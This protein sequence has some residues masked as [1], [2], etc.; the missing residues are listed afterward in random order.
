MK[1]VI[2]ITGFL[3][4]GMSLSFAQ[5][6]NAL[7]F[8]GV[9][10]YVQTGYSGI[11]GNQAR[12][13][14][15]WIRTTAN[16][17][18]SA[19][20]SQQVIVDWGSAVTGGRCTFNILWGNSIRFE[21]QGN[22]IGGTTPVNDGIWHHLAMTY[23]PLAVNK[24]KLYI[25]GQL[26]TEGNLTVP[27]NT[28]AQTDLRIGMRVDGVKNFTG[29]IDEVRVW[30]IVRTQS[31]ISADMNKEYC[32]IPNG[33]EVYYKANEGI[34]NGVN[35]G[36][37]TLYNA[38]SNNHHGTLTNFAL[39]GGV[40]NWV[41]G[42]GISSGNTSFSFQDTACS[43]YMMP[44][45]TL[46]DSSGIYVDVIPNNAGCDSIITIDVTIEQLDW[47]V[48]VDAN[49]MFTATS[50]EPNATYQWIDCGTFTPIVGE[51]SN[52]F[53]PLVNGEYAL[54]I[55]AG[56]CRDTSE[57]VSIANIGLKETGLFSVE[58]FPNPA[59]DVVR[60]QA[61]NR[62]SLRVFNAQGLCVYESGRILENWEIDVS[63]W[64]AGFYWVSAVSQ[65]GN[66]ERVLVK[67]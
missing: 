57:C 52:T 65:K 37:Q 53:T 62:V 50:T 3:F 29:D 48:S 17:N 4:L 9:D 30:N 21:A 46:Y 39:S 38:V 22:G 67:Q 8:D 14:E 12:T 49:N 27:V 13:V 61:D 18:P 19:G 51:T 5:N 33:L 2:V 16:C 42:A 45:G 31:E 40:S 54:E 11:L 23:D 26:E 24:V 47:Q 63:S 15:A 64:P 44:S 43:F 7:N 59:I 60:I 66:I 56:S 35:A 36:A 1:R 6:Q 34:A 58:V 20:G 32:V 28:I 55:S 25:D 41:N 10:D